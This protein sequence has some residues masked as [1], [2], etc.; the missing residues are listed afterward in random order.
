M[1]KRK[2]G[3]TFFSF[4]VFIVFKAGCYSIAQ[5]GHMNSLCS[6]G[7]ELTIV[8]L[9]P[10]P[11][12]LDFRLKQPQELAAMLTLTPQGP[13]HTREVAYGCWLEE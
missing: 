4:Y 10:P 6:V 1:G 12:Y 5:T 2:F 11:E 8:L 13:T 7:L 9:A 3:L